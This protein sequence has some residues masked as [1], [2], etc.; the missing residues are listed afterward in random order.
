MVLSVVRHWTLRDRCSNWGKARRVVSRLK[1]AQNLGRRRPVG[2]CP[3]RELRHRLFSNSLQKGLRTLCLLMASR[4]RVLYLQLHRAF[5]LSLLDQRAKTAVITPGQHTKK[6]NLG[7]RIPKCFPIS[8]PIRS[9]ARLIATLQICLTWNL[10]PLHLEG[11]PERRWLAII[12]RRRSLGP[13]M[14]AFSFDRASF[15][16]RKALLPP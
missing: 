16:H 12:L 10:P 14:G 8:T 7:D 11:R 15:K 5:L 2:G 13:D 1:C 3:P 6:D 9:P 4:R